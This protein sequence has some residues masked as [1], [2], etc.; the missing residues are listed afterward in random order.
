MSVI[1]G[2]V[3]SDVPKDAVYR[4]GDGD[5]C[6][7]GLACRNS[8]CLA[9]V[10]EIP[11]ASFDVPD[12]CTQLTCQSQ[13]A[14]CGAISDGCGSVLQC[15]QCAG[16]DVCG[17]GPSRIPNKCGCT[18]L[19]TAVVCQI[20]GAT[21]G[22]VERFDGCGVMSVYTCGPPCAPDGGCLAETGAEL[23]T[24]AKYDCG[25]LGLKDRC[26][27]FRL[28]N[29]GGCGTGTSCRI[30]EETTDGGQAALCGACTPED[31]ATLCNRHGASCGQLT[32]RPDGGPVIDNC[33]MPRPPLNC[34]A[35][36]DMNNVD[37]CGAAGGSRPNVCICQ[38]PLSGCLETAQC[39]AGSECGGN[40]M[41]CVRPGNACSDDSD[42]CFG[43]CSGRPDGGLGA[44][45]LVTAGVGP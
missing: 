25:M 34:G 7:E 41:C 15:G 4:C 8:F 12:A 33:G 19:T 40:G 22:T 16:F 1:G 32:T 31:D 30:D 13:G 27:T 6:P 14:L 38:A 24:K 35:C 2:C 26:N 37:K 39:C 10:Q 28:V 5:A 23:C 17:G 9:L 42:C 36:L 11:D 44:I 3:W 45:C 29:C 43:S 20:A 18:A 21:C